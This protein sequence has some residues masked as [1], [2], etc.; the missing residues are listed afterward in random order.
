ML[1]K[2]QA[3]S[4]AQRCLSSQLLTLGRFVACVLVVNDCN[5]QADGWGLNVWVP[6]AQVEGHASRSRDVRR[7]G[8]VNELPARG[9]G[10]QGRWGA[11]AMGSKGDIL[12]FSLL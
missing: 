9:D 8:D 5:C 3:S 4:C 6:V 1:V 7:T 10:E 11:G 12:W 2:L